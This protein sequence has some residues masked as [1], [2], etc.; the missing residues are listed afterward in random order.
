MEELSKEG[1]KTYNARL[2]LIERQRAILAAQGQ[3]GLAPELQE[4]IERTEGRTGFGFEEQMA[5]M[6]KIAGARPGLNAEKIADIT[7]QLEDL[8]GTPEKLDDVVTSFTGVFVK[9][10]LSPK[11]LKGFFDATGLNLRVEL[12]KTFGVSP[13]EMTK[14]MGKKGLA[15]SQLIAGLEKTLDRLTGVGGAFQGRARAFLETFEG[16]QL[17]WGYLWDNFVSKWGQ[18]VEQFITPIANEFLNLFS[19][20]RMIAGMDEFIGWATRM[21]IAI[22]DMMSDIMVSGALEKFGA[23]RRALGGIFDI[24]DPSKLERWMQAGEDIV[25]VKTPLAEMLEGGFNKALDAVAE[26]VNKLRDAMGFIYDH[27]QQIKQIVIDIALVLAAERVAMM[28]TNFG[29]FAKM[30][31]GGAAAGGEGGLLGMVPGVIKVPALV[32]I[33]TSWIGQQFDKTFKPPYY[34]Q[35]SGQYDWSVIDPQGSA[36]AAEQEKSKNAD[37]VQKSDAIKKNMDSAA[38]ATDQ[39]RSAF[40]QIAQHSAFG[41]GSGGGGRAAL[42]AD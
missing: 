18:A 1:V 21:G 16:I 39:I 20:E 33:I 13:D 38:A 12:A 5:A 25:R 31:G 15:P 26:I 3:A 24:F 40:D 32:G 35:K 14:L 17:R 22:K 6:T 10:G 9:G 30:L 23:I 11:A 7:Q 36:M 2:K 8:A 41:L 19:N 37:A 27:F 42:R 4:Q 29:N 28:A 34:D